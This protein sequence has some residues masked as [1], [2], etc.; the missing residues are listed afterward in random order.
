MVTGKK[1]LF[2]LSNKDFKIIFSM[3]N[4]NLIGIK[5]LAEK[6]HLTNIT[7]LLYFYSVF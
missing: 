4:G 3:H 6:A 1:T 7:L 2:K 5:N